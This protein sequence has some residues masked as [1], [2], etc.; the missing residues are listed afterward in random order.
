MLLDE[1][2]PTEISRPRSNI[3]ILWIL[4]FGMA[5]ALVGTL[6]QMVRA[7][8]LAR[9]L[10]FAQRSARGEIARVSEAASSATRAATSAAD[11]ASA[12]LEQSE[13]RFEELSKQVDRATSAAV[14]QA[15]A[16]AKRNNADLTRNVDKDHQQLATDLSDL[17]RETSSKLDQVSND[18]ER[19]GSDLKRVVGDLG[20]M[21]GNIAT[22]SKEL[23]ALRDLGERN[24]FE[25]DLPKAKGPMRVGDIRLILKKADPKHSR[26]TLEVLAD[27]TTVEKKDRTINEPVQLY[28]AGTRQPYEI[29]VNH[30]KK[31]QVVGYLATPKVRT[32]RS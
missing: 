26:F 5:L 23:S 11:A 10:S 1:P 28:V 24:Y 19:T 15:K 20:V 2:K 4:G 17:K 13:R 14:Q 21:S 16:E 7:N 12:V 9:E 32:P 3:G 30:V 6:F 31:N 22:N 25:F 29:V 18:V 27:D 8:N